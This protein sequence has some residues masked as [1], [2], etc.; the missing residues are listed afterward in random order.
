VDT[1]LRDGP[2]VNRQNVMQI[3]LRCMSD[4]GFGV[5]DLHIIVFL[6]IIRWHR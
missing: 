3:C 4:E 6:L 5:Q 2:N 1:V